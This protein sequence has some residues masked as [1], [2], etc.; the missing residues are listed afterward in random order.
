MLCLTP[1]RQT[2]PRSELQGRGCSPGITTSKYYG[3]CLSGTSPFAPKTLPYLPERSSLQAMAEVFGIF[4]GVLSALEV[5]VKSS[6]S[7]VKL[8]ESYRSHNTTVTSFQRELQ[9]LNELISEVQSVIDGSPTE[10]EALNLPLRQCAGMSKH[11][12]FGEF[13]PWRNQRSRLGKCQN[14]QFNRFH[15]LVLGHAMVP[16]SHSRILKRMRS[17]CFPP[18]N[19]QGYSRS[20]ILVD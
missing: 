6:L 14:Q 20:T 15:K 17:I 12:M 10:S 7:L 5:T 19:C 16:E 9:S 18:Q 2:L 11:Q 13:S 1:P 8:I 4:S 3:I